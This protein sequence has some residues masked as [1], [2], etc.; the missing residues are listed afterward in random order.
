M[1]AE[2]T[3]PANEALALAETMSNGE[4]AQMAIAADLLGVDYDTFIEMLA[5]EAGV[6]IESD[7]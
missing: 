6:Q 1:D 4:A 7:K 3:R 2:K 5:K